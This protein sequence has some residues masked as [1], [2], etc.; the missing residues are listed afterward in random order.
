[1]LAADQIT[2]ALLRERLSDTCLPADPTDVVMPP[3]SD[4]WP[5][6]IRSALTESLKPAGV[7]IPVIERET[8]LTVL[9][10]QRSAEL[11]PKKSASHPTMSP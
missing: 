11:K 4:N 2:T 9:L 1:M 7:L 3:G 6:E 5:E 8:G 10:T